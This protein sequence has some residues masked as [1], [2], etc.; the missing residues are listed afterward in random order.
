MRMLVAQKVAFNM[1]V[2]TILSY[3]ISGQAL[4]IDFLR[5]SYL[6]APCREW[7]QRKIIKAPVRYL[8]WKCI[9]A[10]NNQVLAMV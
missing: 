7:A 10:I 9:H 4:V 2:L 5:D 1:L 8:Q 6:G 3:S